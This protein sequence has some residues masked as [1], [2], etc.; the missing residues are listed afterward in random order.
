MSWTGKQLEADIGVK[1]RKEKL[2]KN[3]NQ[4]AFNHMYGTVH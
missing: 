1:S 2:A 4:A 3:E